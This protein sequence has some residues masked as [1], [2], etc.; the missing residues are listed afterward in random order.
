MENLKLEVN[1]ARGWKP[2]YGRDEYYIEQCMEFTGLAREIVV[3]TLN[4]G[5]EIAFRFGL[6][7]YPEWIPMIRKEVV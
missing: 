4:S 6:E 3:E 1:T 5:K 2:S 7:H